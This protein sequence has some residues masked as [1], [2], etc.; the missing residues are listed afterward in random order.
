MKLNQDLIREILLAIEASDHDPIEWIDN[1]AIQN[2]PERLVSYHVQ[3]LHEAGFIEAIDLTTNSGYEWAPKRLTYQGHQFLDGIR[4]PK[5][6]RYA[7]EASKQ[8]GTGAIEFLFQAA[9]AY[10]KNEFKKFTGLD[11]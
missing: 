8:A 9:K 5:A 3:L 7:K 4:D 10:A 6:W 2:Q 11:L 1:F